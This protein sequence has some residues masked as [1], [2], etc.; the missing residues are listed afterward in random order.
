MTDRD[1]FADFDFDLPRELIAAGRPSRARRRAS[2]AASGRRL[3][4]RHIATCRRYAAG[5]P[6]RRQR[7]QGDPAGWS[8][9]AAWRRSN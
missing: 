3:A 7:H 1:A 8:G 5:R 9:G 4:D 2:G 6:P